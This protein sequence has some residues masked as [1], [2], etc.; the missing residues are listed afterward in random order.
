MTEA[1]TSLGGMIDYYGK[2]ENGVITRYG[3][4]IPLNF[5]MQVNTRLQSSAREIKEIIDN[6]I[7]FLPRGDKIHPNWVVCSINA[8]LLS[9]N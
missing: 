3:A 8:D 1:Y 2:V 6:C 9:K 7:G 5:E 4:E